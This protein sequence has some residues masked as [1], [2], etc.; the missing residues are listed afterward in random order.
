MSKLL[1]CPFCGTS[2]IQ[3]DEMSRLNW[4]GEEEIYWRV[5]CPECLAEIIGDAEGE[6]VGAWNTRTP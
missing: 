6:A 4:Q 5:M 3:A 1:P 2:T